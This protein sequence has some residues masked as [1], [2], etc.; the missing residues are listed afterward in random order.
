[1]DS[2]KRFREK[3]NPDKKCFYNSVEDGTAVDNGKKL[4]G[5]ISDWD[6]FTCKKVWNEFNMKNMSDYHDHYLKKDVLLLADVLKSL[7]IYASNFKN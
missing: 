6:Y 7:L 3:K 5:H 1:M 2:F 4:D